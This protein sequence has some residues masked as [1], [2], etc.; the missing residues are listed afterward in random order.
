MVTYSTIPTAKLESRISAIGIT[1]F[2]GQIAITE[3]H[4]H[5]YATLLQFSLVALHHGLRFSANT[6]CDFFK[7]LFARIVFL[8]LLLLLLKFL[9]ELFQKV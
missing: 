5:G 4:I 2:E 6:L 8:L 1:N 7:L 9:I 3:G